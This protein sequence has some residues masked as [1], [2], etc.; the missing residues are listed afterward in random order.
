MFGQVS[1]ESDV[2]VDAQSSFTFRGFGVKDLEEAE[3]LGVDLLNLDDLDLS[4]NDDDDGEPVGVTVNIVDILAKRTKDVNQE[5]RSNARDSHEC[6]SGDL[7]N[8]DGWT[9]TPLPKQVRCATPTLNLIM[10]EIDALFAESQFGQLAPQIMGTL[11]KVWS[12]QNRSNLVAEK[13]KAKLGNLFV[14][15][16]NTR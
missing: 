10:Q 6:L 3:F 4:D 11:T 8:D 5:I 14:I 9:E 7:Y 16:V 2:A 1:P 13:I 12:L 15:P